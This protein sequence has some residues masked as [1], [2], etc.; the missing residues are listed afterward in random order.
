M[1]E[2]TATTTDVTEVAGGAMM[3]TGPVAMILTVTV[4]VIMAVTM[5]VVTIVTTT[6]T[7]VSTAM[8]PLA[9]KNA[10]ASVASVTIAGVTT[11]VMLT[12]LVTM[13]ARHMLLAAPTNLVRMTGMLGE[14]MSAV[15]SQPLRDKPHDFPFPV[16][17]CCNF[18]TP[19]YLCPFFFLS[20]S[21]FSYLPCVPW[22]GSIRV[23]P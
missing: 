1:A 2:V 21:M 9:A 15:G 12:L 16:F 13:H 14:V 22:V 5:V 17:Q 11:T 18:L 10:V 19:L 3:T 23:S 4:A 7:A 20:S 8:L 6:V